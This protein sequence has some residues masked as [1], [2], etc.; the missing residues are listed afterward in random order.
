MSFQF[1]QFR[2]P[3]PQIAIPRTIPI[4]DP[5]LNSGSAPETAPKSASETAAESAPELILNTESKSG[6]SDSE[7]PPLMAIDHRS[8]E[9]HADETTK[10]F[11]GN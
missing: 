7:L 10:Y 5:I 9:N 8:V 2:L 6:R 3:L 4:P 1:S 11:D